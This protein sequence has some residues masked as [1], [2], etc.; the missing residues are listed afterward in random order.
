MQ[1]GTIFVLVPTCL[2][3]ILANLFGWQKEKEACERLSKHKK[4]LPWDTVEVRGEKR[5]VIMQK[6]DPS[7]IRWARFLHVV[8]DP[9]GSLAIGQNHEFCKE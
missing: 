1:W 4:G 7:T 5:S 2:T 8:V 3:E 9:Y 6:N